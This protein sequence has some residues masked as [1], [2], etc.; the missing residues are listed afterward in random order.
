MR[1]YGHVPA[2]LKPTTGI[3]SHRNSKGI[4]EAPK[5]LHGEPAATSL[6]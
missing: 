5:A 3:S 1:K 4:A 2:L 6:P